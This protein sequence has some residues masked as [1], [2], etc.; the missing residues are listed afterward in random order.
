MIQ[1][2][3]Q[4]NFSEP[5]FAGDALSGDPGEWSEGRDAPMERALT[6]PRP[7]TEDEVPAMAR[8]RIAGQ[9]RLTVTNIQNQAAPFFRAFLLTEQRLFV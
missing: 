7:R 1:P 4:H 5:T 2:P 9:L 8:G 3:S 6:H